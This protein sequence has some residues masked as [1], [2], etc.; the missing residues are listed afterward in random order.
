MQMRLFPA[1]AASA[2]KILYIFDFDITLTK[3]STSD[4]DFDLSDDEVLLNVKAHLAECFRSIL[5][6]SHSLCMVTRN[7]YPELIRRHLL[8]SGLTVH[9][10]NQIPIKCYALLKSGS[11][12]EWVSDFIE[13]S[14]NISAV[15]YYDDEEN[16]L[17]L[18]EEELSNRILFNPYLINLK[19]NPILVPDEEDYCEHLTQ[20][21][22]S[23]KVQPSLVHALS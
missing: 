2:S 3:E 6:A 13:S 19:F 17:K 7:P 8:A 5:A 4:F 9:E 20:I 12:P 10:V 21:I 18:A 23:L 14:A 22:S 16:Y 1:P 15:Y 11:K